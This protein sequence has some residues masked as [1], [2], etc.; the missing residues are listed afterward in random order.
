M[1]FG[2]LGLVVAALFTGA[3][4]YINLV[5]HPA[6]AMLDPAAQLREWKPSYRRGFAMQASLAV[7][8][9]VLGI[10]AFFATGQWRFLAGGVLLGGNW[11]YTL[12]AIMPTNARLMAMSDAEAGEDSARL[13]DNWAQLHMVRTGLGALSTLVFAWALV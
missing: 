1:G 4:L 7:L 11:P 6:R 10:G 5:E 9:L 12:I 3:A 2:L 8:G 13:I